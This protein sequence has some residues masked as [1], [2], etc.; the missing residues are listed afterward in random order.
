MKAVMKQLGDWM[1]DI[2]RKVP[3]EEAVGANGGYLVPE[4]LALLWEQRWQ[5]VGIFRSLARQQP[6][7][8][9][10]CDVPAF[11]LTAAHAAGASPLFGGMDLRWGVEGATVTETEPGFSNAKLVS[12]DLQGTVVASNQLVADGGE[13]LGAF[14]TMGFA[15]AIDWAV[16]RACFVSQVGGPAGIVDSPATLTAASLD[17][18]I[19]SLLPGC[20]PNAIWAAHPNAIQSEFLGTIT[21]AIFGSGYFQYKTSLPSLVGYAFGRPVYATEKLPA[22]GQ[23]R[24]MLFDPTMYVLGHRGYEV[25]VSTHSKFTTNQTV[26]RIWWRGDGQTIPRGTALLQDGS[27]ASA[28]FVAR[29]A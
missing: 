1:R 2:R 8:S 11:D 24:V 29:A 4:E 27:H 21:P 22:T 5:E 6:M 10:T 13:P 23:G 12:K 26:F 18:M 9:R 17:L 25:A 7:T 15:A 20:Y 16:E 14:L 19:E 3:M 28:A